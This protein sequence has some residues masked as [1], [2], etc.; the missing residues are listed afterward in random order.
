MASPQRRQHL[1]SGALALRREASVFINCPYDPEYAEIFD[2]LIFSTLCCGFVPRCAIESGTIS[3]P[4][5]T[6]IVKAM[7]SS[8]YSIHDLIRCQGQGD[9]NLARF[10]MPLELGMAMANS[11]GARKSSAHDWLVLVPK[12]HPYRKYISDLAGYDPTEHDGSYAT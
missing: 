5:M 10:N 8:K 1:G 3:E 7:R 6:R 4:R 2:A 12:G 9:G 11:V